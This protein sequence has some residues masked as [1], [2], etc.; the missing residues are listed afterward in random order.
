LCTKAW[1]AGWA[2]ADLQALEL[3]QQC[4]RTLMREVLTDVDPSTGVSRCCGSQ[5]CSAWGLMQHC[6]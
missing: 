5:L 3:D 4:G 6:G 1:R 2:A